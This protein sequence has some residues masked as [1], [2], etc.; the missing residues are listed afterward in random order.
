MKNKSV[1]ILIV[2]LLLLGIMSVILI[3]FLHKAK[4]DFPKD[5]RVRE[6]GVTETILPVR[7]LALI[8]TE[9]RTYEVDL[10]CAASGMYHIYLTYEEKTNGGMKAF[11]DVTVKIED[12]TIYEG[13]LAHLLDGGEVL[14]YEGELH[15]TEPMCISVTYHMPYDVSND[16][17]GT[18]SD[19]DIHLKIKKS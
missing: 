5:I 15:A 9:S 11:V 6:N 1:N 13:K 2:A 12:Q 19:F 18:H 8:P 7:D 16:A 17:Q 10:V 3:T 14:H 4:E